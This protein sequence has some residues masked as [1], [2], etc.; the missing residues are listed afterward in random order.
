MFKKGAFL[1]FITVFL[2]LILFPSGPGQAQGYYFQLPEKTVDV[3]WQEDGT[4]ALQYVYVF[5]NDPQSGPIEYVDVAMPNPNFD[6]STVTANVNGRTLDDI[7]TSGYQGSGS[8]VAV[9]L[10]LY[11]IKPGQTGT[12]TVYIGTIRDVLYFDSGDK[13][14]ASAVFIPNY[15]QSSIIH[16]I[17]ATTVTFHLPPGVKPEEPRWHPAPPGFNDPPQTALDQDGRV[18]YTWVNESASGSRE[19]KFGA[20]F[21]V[22]YIPETVIQRENPFAGLPKIDPGCLIPIAVIGFFI[23]MGVV[24]GRANRQRKLQ[25]LPPQISIEGH[26]IKR[27]LTAVEAAILLEQPMEKILTMI[28]FAV[29]KK[30]AAEVVKRDPLEINAI[31]P[32]PDDLRAYEKGFIEAFKIAQPSSRQRELRTVIIDLVKKVALDMKGFSRR[33]TLDYYRN[34][35]QKAWEQVEAAQT[36]EVKS[37]KFDEVME[38][39]M[40]DKEYD[41][42]TKRVF[43]DTPVFIPTWWGH[44]DPT[45]RGST[46]PRTSTSVPGGPTGGPVSLPH[47][48]GS[49]FAASVVNQV[50]NFSSKVVGN[51]TDFTNSVTNTTNPAPKPT[52]S[53]SYHS[54]GRSGGSSC[55]CAC[56]CACAG[57]AC[58]CAGGGR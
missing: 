19:Y 11:A 13:N 8:G 45:Y 58:A 54:G 4:M 22:T 52:S 16:G 39:T 2:A 3:F 28:L 44:F 14:Y 29:V 15:F 31:E 41:D 55:V 48:P 10:G 17:T 5:K 34:I 7:S 40:L 36:P 26:G 35:V 46:F 32:L 24:G 9:G 23:L 43:R 1:L 27:G 6:E 56:A 18:T 33:E 25:Y 53:G 38:W 21:P 12:V 49:D 51:I 30:G 37:Q 50:Q 42:R 20:S 47:L 57:C